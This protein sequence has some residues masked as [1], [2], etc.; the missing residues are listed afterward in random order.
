MAAKNDDPV[1]GLEN[2]VEAFT[3]LKTKSDCRD[4]L[5]DIF[6]PSELQAIRDR[7][8]VAERV[9]KGE[10]YRSIALATLCSTATITRVARTLKF[11]R[12][13]Y[14]RY[15]DRKGKKQS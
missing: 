3:L 4:F 13:G 5:F 2:L 6:T 14:K 10:N 8:E 7:L 12:G 11:G 1:Q 9:Q 15:L